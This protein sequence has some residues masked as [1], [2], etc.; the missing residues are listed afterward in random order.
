MSKFLAPQNQYMKMLSQ[1]W[2]QKQPPILTG[3]P[4]VQK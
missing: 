2:L 3:N 4:S 1:E